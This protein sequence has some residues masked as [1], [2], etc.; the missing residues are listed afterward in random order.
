MTKDPC[1]TCGST[2]YTF[3]RGIASSKGYYS[4]C[5]KCDKSVT[6]PWMPDA[7]FDESKGA[8]QTDPNLCGKDGKRIPFSSKREKA[9]ILKQLNLREAG[10]KRHGG[11]VGDKTD[12]RH[13]RKQWEGA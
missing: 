2:D 3:F 12:Q 7:Y 11:R 8:N 13:G 4:V 6:A 10:D 5:E 9:V 1:Q